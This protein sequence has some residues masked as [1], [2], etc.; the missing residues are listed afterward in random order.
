MYAI[1]YENRILLTQPKWNPKMFNS[2]LEDELDIKSTL[3]LS[4]EIK[5]PITIEFE[6][7]AQR[8]NG[9]KDVLTEVQREEQQPVIEETTNEQKLDENGNPI[10][11]TVII[12][13]TITREEQQPVI[14]ETTNEQKLDENGNPIFQTVIVTETI[15]REE[16]QPVIEETTNK[17]KLDE[18]GNPIFQ[19][20]II[21]E[22]I[23]TQEPVYET[24]METKQAKI[25]PC[26][27]IYPSY[28]LKIEWLSGPIF[29]IDENLVIATYEAKPLDLDIAK[30]NLIDK[31]P[32][33]RYAK[34]VQSINIELNDLVLTISTDRETRAVYANKLIGMGENTINWKFPEGWLTLNKADLEYIIQQIDL[35][36]QEA[37]D[38][39]LSKLNEI[40]VCK[41]LEEI[42][43]IVI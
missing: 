10:F 16:Q 14:D 26:R 36:V 39:E 22:T 13:E 41:T 34:E 5:V 9:T 29:Q 30:G 21:T 38:W 35:A 23:T 25:L 4:D 37:F 17:Q 31:L 11:Q 32:S 15:T 27:E 8:Q 6:K 24:Y 18:N 43:K 7:P 20:V 33:A 2:V 40:K 3:Q 12:T 1:A 28:N 19:T 42:D